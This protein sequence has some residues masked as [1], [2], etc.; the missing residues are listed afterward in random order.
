MR[1]KLPIQGAGGGGKGGGDGDFTQTADNLRSEDVFEGL[2][3]LGHGK[4]KGLTRGLKSLK[5]NGTPLQDASGS[6]NFPDWSILYAN[7]DPTMW[8]QL[9][10]LSL[11]A[12]AAAIPISV[13]L[14]NPSGT[15]T[16]V[17]RTV[18]NTGA[19]FIDLRFVVA[20][21]WKQTKKG[22]FAHSMDI[23][24]RMKPSGTTTW[25]DVLADAT[26]TEGIYGGGSAPDG[27]P[28]AGGM[29]LVMSSSYYVL[30][31]GGDSKPI[32]GMSVLGSPKSFYGASGHRA[33]TGSTPGCLTINGKTTQPYVKEVRIGVPNT[34]AYAGV[35]WD[36]ECTLMN[37]DTVNADPNFEKREVTWES[38]AAGYLT[39]FGSDAAWKGQ[40]WMQ[41]LGT[42]SDRVS[43]IPAIYG[44]WDTKEV[45][46]PPS[47]VFDPES[48]LYTTTLW[49]GSWV[50][51]FTTD[52]A[53]ILND[54]ISDP[55]GGV[56][57]V[58]LGAY[59]NKWDALELSKNCSELVPD[60]DL[61]QADF[62]S[63]VT[64]QTK[65][66]CRV[67]ASTDINISSAPATISGIT[68]STGD[69]VLL[70]GQ[71]SAADNGIYVFNG[72]SSAMTRATDADTAGELL[73]ACVYVTEGTFA[74]RHF[75]QC[76][77]IT[78]LGSSNVKWTS[79]QPR[80]ELNV[81]FD[82]PQKADE[83]IKNLA[84]AVGAIAWDNGN[85]EWRTKVE[86]AETPVAIF[87]EE[88]IEGEF[89]YS[90]TDVDTRY[91]DITMS[92]KN[93]EFDYREDRVRV[94][95]QADIDATGRRTTTMVAIGCT[96]RQEAY[97]RAYLRLR[98]ALNEYR[99]VSFT[100]NRLGR[101]YS[102][103]STILIADKSLG[104]TAPTGSTPLANTDERDHTTGRIIAMD[105][106]RTTI[107]LRDPLRLEPGATYKI[108]L[109]VPNPDYAPTPSTEPTSPDFNKPTIVIE[110]TVDAAS[111]RGDVTSI[112]LTSALPADTPINAPIALDA[113]G[114]PTLPKTYRIVDVAVGEDGERVTISAIEVDTGKWAAADTVSSAAIET[115]ASDPSCPPPT[116]PATG[117][118]HLRTFPSE[119]ATIQVLE[120]D[121]ERPA[122]KFINGYGVRYRFNG[123]PWVDLG[124]TTDT[125]IE[126]QNPEWGFYDVEIVA[127]DRRGEQSVP[128]TASIEL[129]ESSLTGLYGSLTN[130]SHVV[131]ADSSGVVSS[132]AGASG[133]FKCFVGTQEVT[134][135]CTFAITSNPQTLTASIT[136]ATG[137][138]SVTGG[139]DAGESSAT[140]TFTATH[141][142]T[143]YTTSR[144]FS[145]GKAV[146]GNAGANGLTNSLV[147]IYKRS[148]SAPSLP[149][150]T[151]TFTF[152][153]GDVTGLDNGWTDTIPAG[154]DPLYVALAT[155]SGTSSSDTIAAAEWTT[156]QIMTSNGLNAA[157]VY[158][159]QRSTTAPSV[160]S[161]TSTY[162]FA[163]GV[164]TG[165]DNN[166]VQSVPSGTD[167]LY[168]TT[169]TAA[170][171]DTTDTIATGEWATPQVLAASGNYTD[172]RWKRSVSE[173]ATPTG[174]APVGWSTSVPTG[175][176]SLWFSSVVK[177]ASGA[178][179]G[180][181]STPARVSSTTFRGAYASGTTYYQFDVVTF[182]GGT[183]IAIQNNFSGQAPSG[184]ANA[185]AYWDV[186]AAPGDEGAPGTPPSGFT[187][188]I[189]LTSGAAVNLR[190]A[191]DAA[192]YTGASDATIT[193]KVPNGVVCRGLGG[194]P[195]GYGIDTGTWPSGY[196]IALTL[197]IESGGIVDGG[198]GNGGE[199]GVGFTDGYTGKNGGDAI[200][201][202]VNMSGGI[203]ID[204]GG[205]VRGG[206]GG[207][208]GGGGRYYETTVGGEL[209]QRTVGGG[210]GGGGFPNGD[211]GVGGPGD[212]GSGNNGSAGTTAG[213]GAGGT[214][215]TG[216]GTGGT[217]G[218]DGTAATAGAN[219]TG[220]VG[221]NYYNGTGGVG[222]SP[223]YAVRKNG[224]TATVT[225][226]GTMTGTAG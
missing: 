190:A 154:T 10:S 176:D 54:V 27:I 210:G 103:L 102:P 213:G 106:P 97:R 111:P 114:L 9:T 224:Y 168:V 79:C 127:Y 164:L 84:G 206:S 24:V 142:P 169:A 7:G 174:T 26:A 149:T 59:L 216:C 181:W 34:G 179:V 189:N 211:G 50:K 92:Y 115:Q 218:G 66:N 112:L 194:N 90:H 60:G 36:I 153:T 42:A 147:Y 200:Y 116:A 76:Q 180:A 141:T 223:G 87:T 11:G 140:I 70:F 94:W 139:F 52:P 205:T 159:Y 85:G 6:I 175:T 53:W 144:V 165:H 117:V 38:A 123:G 170:G 202:R 8:P 15:G 118:L 37:V 62:I 198:G 161:T 129:D 126:I 119:Y 201:L 130:D 113:P 193:F 63:G 61:N 187:A 146:A 95:D 125:R 4:W 83:M 57:A 74:E 212:F 20:Q 58:A 209:Q 208:G 64:S 1:E 157:I 46:V 195:G 81:T 39:Q 178:L 31:S 156:P 110:R 131:Q 134:A 160:P 21:L 225:N 71:S 138:Y 105:G 183:Y 72:A 69:R 89:V 73:G 101:F 215:G 99:L 75:K 41:I 43:G 148:A 150:A 196:T 220:T 222:G 128:L 35:G 30:H 93:R 143:G 152:A 192:G 184:N 78:T 107:T 98:S 182:N 185:T 199:G 68:L 172:F 203:T 19:D 151:A 177:S 121:W 45:S 56:G 17:V 219:A 221:D 167:P 48:R 96:N 77:T 25:I 13:Q 162:T 65:A 173:P 145:L 155:A 186:M 82:Q 197:V 100:T 217:G 166:W 108:K 51:A 86:K 104:Y 2:L 32:N 88:N 5:I 214:G 91:N 18:P 120:V 49:D 29:T 12:A 136:D 124:K 67:A 133:V 16:P 226:N 33:P 22:I 137:A 204:A 158:L 3:G 132:Y 40:V 171:T 163:T 109:T 122:S 47:T 135:D 28:V 188:T 80:Y 55:I 207:G 14:A 23:R 191:A 44:E